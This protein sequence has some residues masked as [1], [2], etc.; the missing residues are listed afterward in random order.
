MSRISEIVDIINDNLVANQ[1]SSDKFKSSKIVCIAELLN[2]RDGDIDKSIPAVIDNSGNAEY[3]GQDDKY[4]F[5]IYHRNLGQEFAEDSDE[6]YGDADA[7]SVIETVNMIM[8]VIYDKTKIEEDKEE[9][10]SA[11]ANG[12][13]YQLTKAQVTNINAQNVFING[14]A[15]NVNSQEVFDS[16]FNSNKTRRTNWVYISMPY[17][18]EIH[19]KKGCFTLC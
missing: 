11:I 1:F 18:I 17:T 7:V 13:T 12:W 15:F 4:S 3:V 8:V 2:I 9:I 6:S 19:S 14:G 16:E 10:V 5:Q